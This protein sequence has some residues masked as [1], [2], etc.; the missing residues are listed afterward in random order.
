MNKDHEDGMT[1]MQKYV[2]NF[3]VLLELMVV[4]MVVAKI[5]SS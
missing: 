4:T 2:N 1:R 5:V 3:I